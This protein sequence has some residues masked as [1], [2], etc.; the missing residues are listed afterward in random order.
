MTLFTWPY[1]VVVHPAR[2]DGEEVPVV[3]AAARR[4]RGTVAV[5]ITCVRAFIMR[6]SSS[7]IQCRTGVR[8]PDSRCVWQPMFAVAI[9][10]GRDAS[11]A[12]SLFALSWFASAGC[13]TE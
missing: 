5:L 13:R 4:R 8:V 1:A 6:V 12:R 7:S 9:T 3:G 2:R 11:S 10:C